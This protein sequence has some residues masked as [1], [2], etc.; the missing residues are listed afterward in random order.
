MGGITVL[1]F[2]REPK[3]GRASD[4]SYGLEGSA[5]AQVGKNN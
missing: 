1:R 5:A 3:T 4:A 2:T